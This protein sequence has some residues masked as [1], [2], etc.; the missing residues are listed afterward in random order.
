MTVQPHQILGS[1]RRGATGHVRFVAQ[2]ND[3]DTVTITG[4][5]GTAVVY[6]FDNNAAS[7]AGNIRVTIGADA[8]ATAAALRAA[9]VANQSDLL[10]SVGPITTVGG[11]L[12]CVDLKGNLPGSGALTLAESTGGARM[13]V[14]DNANEGSAGLLATRTLR[15]V[16]TA[17]DVSRGCVAF[18]F[19]FSDIL[20]YS[21]DLW[22]AEAGGGAA[23]NATRIAWVGASQVVATNGVERLLLDNSG[24]TDFA[25]GQVFYVTA[26][27][28][29]STSL[30]GA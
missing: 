28:E 8:A 2:P 20:D 6:E 11:A 9:V 5:N 13:V 19:G 14:Q 12:Q 7:V 30:V 24:A 18:D 27:G 15:R 4:P 17:E 29:I 22:T 23:A 16:V 10:A 1:G 25:A 26:T 3:A 21:I